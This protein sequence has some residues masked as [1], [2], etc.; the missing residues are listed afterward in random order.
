ME[1]PLDVLETCVT[2]DTTSTQPTYRNSIAA[3]IAV[4]HTEPQRWHP[5][6]A[7]VAQ[8]TGQVHRETARDKSCRMQTAAVRASSSAAL[9]SHCGSCPLPTIVFVRLHRPPLRNVGSWR[10]A[11]AVC[12]KLCLRNP[13][14]K[15]L[16]Q[17]LTDVSVL[18]VCCKILARLTIPSDVP[19]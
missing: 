11:L 1:T 7:A 15:V 2:R 16:L 6:A 14:K 4:R 19:V 17:Q 8:G 9:L 12:F 5:A 13:K 3:R 18:K 10:M